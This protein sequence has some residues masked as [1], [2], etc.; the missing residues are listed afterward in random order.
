MRKTLPIDL[1]WVS[2][3]MLGQDQRSGWTNKNNG[4]MYGAHRLRAT[5]YDRGYM[6]AQADV[7]RSREEDVFAVNAGPVFH[8]KEVKIVGLPEDLILGCLHSSPGIPNAAK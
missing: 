6:S 2:C 3:I 7:K 4:Q 8:F 1:A 5:Y